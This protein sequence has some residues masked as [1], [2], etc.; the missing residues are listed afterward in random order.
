MMAVM[1][2]AKTKNW[3]FDEVTAERKIFS[4]VTAEAMEGVETTEVDKR[5]TIHYD[6]NGGPKAK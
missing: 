4:N 1:T 5:Y 6:V 2:L 3:P